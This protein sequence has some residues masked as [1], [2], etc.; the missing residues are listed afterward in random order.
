MG[1]TAKQEK[2]CQEY[3]IDLNATQAA[4][5]AGYSEKTASR[6]GGQNLYKLVIQAE[7]QRSQLARSKR[8]EITQDR[9]LKELALIGFSDMAM[10]VRID[11]SGMIQANPLDTLPEGASRIIKK[12]KEKRVIRSTPEGDQILDATYEFE[13]CDK[14]RCLELMG[15]HLGMFSENQEQAE[16]Q[17][18]PLVDY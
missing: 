12:V 5:R 2:F 14:V 4:I 8:T 3:L 16:L 10:F 7:I 6:I 17:P 9:V 1:L 18:L 15:K 11:E 13:L